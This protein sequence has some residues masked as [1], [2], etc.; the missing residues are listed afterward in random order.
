MS[1]V[2]KHAVKLGM[3]FLRQYFIQMRLDAMRKTT[4]RHYSSNRERMKA[5]WLPVNAGGIL[6]M[7]RDELLPTFIPDSVSELEQYVLNAYGNPGQTQVWFEQALQEVKRPKVLEEAMG[8]DSPVAAQDLPSSLDDLLPGNK[9]R[10]TSDF[11]DFNF[12]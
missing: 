5:S 4:S 12:D 9:N 11:S 1:L 6:P 10:R 7:A 8:E 3:K 2:E